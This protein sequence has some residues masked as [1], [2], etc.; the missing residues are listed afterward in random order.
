MIIR[1]IFGLLV[2]LMGCTST[3]QKSV[4]RSLIRSGLLIENGPTR[5]MGYTDA[6]GT[7]YGLVYITTTITNDSTLPIQF[8]VALPK[9]YDYP[10]EYGDH[11]FN[12][13]LWPNLNTDHVASLDSMMSLAETYLGKDLNNPYLYRKTL[14]PGAQWVATI[15]SRFPSQS[16]ICSAV[17]YAL[18]EF[19]NRA[20]DPSCGWAT[21]EDHN[22]LSLGLK[23]GFCTVGAEYE[24]C[25][26]L[27][28]GQ[29][30]YPDR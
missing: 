5:G 9:E 23:I 30:A 12:L 1:T 21:H 27:P 24:S 10:S 19:G 6:A 17:P 8:Q 4:N 18:L 28:C 14:E 29:I 26:I 16:V 20:T 11:K 2:V 15:G 3:Q 25:I 13:L 7:K 22:T